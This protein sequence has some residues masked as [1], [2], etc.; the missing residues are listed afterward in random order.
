MEETVDLLTLVPDENHE[1]KTDLEPEQKPNEKPKKKKSK[2][3]NE[4]NEFNP[5]EF[6]DINGYEL[7]VYKSVYYLRDLET[8][9]LYNIKNYQLNQVVGL[10]N[11]K[12]R[13][14]FN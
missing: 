14:K 4:E 9:E 1:P 13:V 2:K 10:I 8:N 12:G 5:E 11:S 7:I 3:V 6:E